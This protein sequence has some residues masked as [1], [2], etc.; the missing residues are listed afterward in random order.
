MFLEC[1][2]GLLCGEVSLVQPAQYQKV[3]IRLRE[4]KINHALHC[5]TE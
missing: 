1:R 2:K 5:K 3:T 4:K